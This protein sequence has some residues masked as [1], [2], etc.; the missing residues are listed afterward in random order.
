MCLIW[1]TVSF[2]LEI[3]GLIFGRNISCKRKL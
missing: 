3:T 2:S 1:S